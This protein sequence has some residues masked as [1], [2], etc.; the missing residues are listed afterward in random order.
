M[1]TMEQEAK[2][3]DQS[4]ELKKLRQELGFTIE[5]Q[6][7]YRKVK[8]YSMP[9]DDNAG[10]PIAIGTVT[11]PV[12]RYAL[13]RT[14]TDEVVT[15]CSKRYEPVQMEEVILRNTEKL[16]SQGWRLPQFE[17]RRRSPIRIEGNGLRAYVELIHPEV[18][19]QVSDHMSSFGLKDIVSPRFVLYNS[20]DAT[21]I[22]GAHAGGYRKLCS[23]GM[24]ENYDF[25][26]ITGGRHMGQFVSRKV[27]DIQ[28]MADTFLE[29]YE[30]VAK[31]WKQMSQTQVSLNRGL[32]AVQEVTVRKGQ[33][34]LHKLERS[35][36]KDLTAWD[37]FNAITRWLTFEYEGSQSLFNAYQVKA[38]AILMSNDPILPTSRFLQPEDRYF[39]RNLALDP[40]EF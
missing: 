13:V 17:L 31:N 6:P 34:V 27:E 1:Q 40:K 33:D 3:K 19:V 9:L 12:D 10:E 36:K 22:Y 5:K 16:Y 39:M 18:N 21:T 32:N 15:T 8:Q 20:Y 4:W 35:W 30:E 29:N 2:E 23:N 14:D 28:K 24:Y 37:W 38:K 26:G 7:L 11:E 25:M